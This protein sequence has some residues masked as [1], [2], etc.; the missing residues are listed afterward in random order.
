MSSA[1]RPPPVRKRASSR[2]RSDLPIPR[3]ATCC[4]E[5]KND[6]EDERL[7]PRRNH[8]HV[9]VSKTEYRLRIVVKD[10]VG[11]GFGQSQ[12]LDI[13]EGLLVGLVIL[14]HRV[15]AAG[16]QMVG[17]EGFEGA[18]ESRLGAVA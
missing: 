4:R 10:L 15:V 17:A 7:S 8:C 16:Y 13:S 9:S 2:R 18:E 12:A 11:I 3:G 1:Y 14:Q 6:I 5:C